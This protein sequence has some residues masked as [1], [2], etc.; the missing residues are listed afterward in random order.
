M[1]RQFGLLC[2]HLIATVYSIVYLPIRV[3]CARSTEVNP[4]WHSVSGASWGTENM[5]LLQT[6]TRTQSMQKSN[7]IP[8]TLLPYIITEEETATDYPKFLSQPPAV[9][10]TYKGNPAVVQ[11]S[12]KPVILLYVVCVI[13]LSPS[14]PRYTRN[15]MR[16]QLREN[17]PLRNQ[18]LNGKPQRNGANTM[19]LDQQQMSVT[20]IVTA[21]MIEEW[22]GDFWCHC[23]AW[24]NGLSSNGPR[25]KLSSRVHIRLACKW[26]D[27][28]EIHALKHNINPQIN[29]ESKYLSYCA[30]YFSLPIVP[31]LSQNISRSIMYSIWVIVLWSQK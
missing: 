14:G 26:Y 8:D 2:V 25:V 13:N 5:K 6:T 17:N 11:C 9:L 21:R 4:F 30:S 3:Y 27:H 20:K 22:F 1:R 19:T 29:F 31:H 16:R 28:V 24:T 23:E 15:H 18:Y 10:Y 12:A 7:P